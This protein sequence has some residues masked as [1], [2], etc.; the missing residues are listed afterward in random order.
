MLALVCGGASEFRKT[1]DL[2]AGWEVGEDELSLLRYRGY[3]N[4]GRLRVETRDGRAFENTYL[5]MWEDESQWCLQNRCK[6]CPD[7]IG[8]AAD[9]AAADYWP[10][11]SPSGEDAGFNSMIARTAAGRALLDEA[12]AGGAITIVRELT[13]R[14]MDATQPHQVRKK[15]AVWARL[16]GMRA[17]GHPVPEVENLR[18]KEIARRR[19]LAALLAEAR[20]A[21]ARVRRGRMSEPP[22]AET[23]HGS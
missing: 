1:R 8:E 12:Q 17:A 23:A 2:L 9:V 11:G 4:P 16:A 14:D 19:P 18:V 13:M 10:G 15:E 3:G 5:D 21:R 7:A 20:G 22:A 6:I